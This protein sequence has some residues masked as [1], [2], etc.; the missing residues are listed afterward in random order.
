MKKALLVIGLIAGCLTSSAEAY[1][2]L[3][4]RSS[5]I[6]PYEEALQGFKNVFAGMIPLRGP[7][8]IHPGTV[9]ELVLSNGFGVRELD[10]RV[11]ALD[12][13]LILAIGREAL[14]QVMNFRNKPIVYLMAPF[15]DVEIKSRPHI[16]G[17]DMTIPLATQLAAL[18]GAI[19]GIKRVGLFYDPERTGKLAAEAKKAAELQGIT[20]IAVEVHTPKKVPKMFFSDMADA[21]DAFWMLPDP[22]VITSETLTTLH[23]FALEDK[24]PILTFAD[25]YMEHGAALS[26][27]FDVY[28]MGK[29]AGEMAKRILYG[30]SVREI[31]VEPPL[32]INVRLN[33]ELANLAGKVR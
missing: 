26:V 16:T 31:P 3:A 10:Q 9:T 32:K 22:T 18:T 5:E 13:D 1:E 23:F 29:Q 11:R 30:T 12:P 15:L 24:M 4:V 33:P 27:S 14:Y 6:Q 25:K 20:L 7:K 17:V 19:S 2:I 28:A 8:T 21:V